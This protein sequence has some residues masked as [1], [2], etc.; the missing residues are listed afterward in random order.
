MKND[1]FCFKIFKGKI[2]PR[3]KIRKTYEFKEHLQITNICLTLRKLVGRKVKRSKHGYMHSH[4]EKKIKK[5][6]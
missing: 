3:F 5:K 6:P 4:I 2:I 1:L